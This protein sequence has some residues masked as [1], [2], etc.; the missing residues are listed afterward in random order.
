MCHRITAGRMMPETA[1]LG[2]VAD[3]EQPLDH[4]QDPSLEPNWINKHPA[5]IDSSVPL[6]EIIEADRAARQRIEGMRKEREEFQEEFGDRED[7]EPCDE[8]EDGWPCEYHATAEELSRSEEE[9]LTTVRG[10]RNLDIFSDRLYF[11]EN[12]LLRLHP[13]DHIDDS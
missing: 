7:T 4:W 6:E 5:E 2:A 11:D 3:L 8:C 1:S 12:G 9:V 10:M 13:P